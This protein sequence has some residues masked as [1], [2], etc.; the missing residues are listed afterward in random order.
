MLQI[1]KTLLHLCGVPQVRVLQRVY[2]VRAGRFQ[3]PSDTDIGAD[4]LVQFRK[5]LEREFDQQIA[6][7]H[8]ERVVTNRFQAFIRPIGLLSLI[9]LL[10]SL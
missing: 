4:E 2:A 10:E 3:L 7:D 5:L 9:R 8:K 6:L 1:L